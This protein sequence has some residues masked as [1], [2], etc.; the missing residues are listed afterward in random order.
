MTFIEKFEQIKKKIGTPDTA[1][2]T[3]DFAVQINMTDADCGGTFY[4]AYHNGTVSIEPYDYYDHTALIEAESAELIAAFDGKNDVIGAI[5]TGRLNVYGNPEHVKAVFLLKKPRAKRTA[6][7]T[8]ENGK[9]ESQ[10][11]KRGRKPAKPK[12]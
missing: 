3:E 6:A 4:I 1:R 10:P 7:K 9:T 8:E 11:K 12:E 2:L 5:M